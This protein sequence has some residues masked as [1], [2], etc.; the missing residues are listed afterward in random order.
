[1]TATRTLGELRRSDEDSFG[2]KSASL[3][4]LI[5]AGVPV[6]PGFALS[7][8]SYLAAVEGIDLG[9]TPEECALSIRSTAVPDR[10]RAEIPESYERL[11]AESGDRRPPVAVRSSAIGEDSEEATFAGQQETFLWV[12][13]IDGICKAVQD[14]WAALASAEADQHRAEIRRVH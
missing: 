6:P 9:G 2:A 3:G 10:L 4:E 5:G 12:R 11:A 1:M 8:E 13:G 7:A 14:C